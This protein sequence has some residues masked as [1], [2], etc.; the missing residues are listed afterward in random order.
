MLYKD[1]MNMKTLLTS[2]P[3]KLYSPLLWYTNIYLS[4][5]LALIL[6]NYFTLSASVFPLFL[7]FWTF[8]FAFSSFHTFSPNIYSAI[9]DPPPAPSINK[10]FP[11]GMLADPY[12]TFQFYMDPDPD[13][14]LD[15]VQKLI[16]N[17][18]VI[19]VDAGAA[20]WGRFVSSFKTFIQRIQQQKS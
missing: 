1:Y 5:P 2:P 15:E 20:V 16:S 18:Y 17:G 4:C 13:P 7:F 3:R 6:D 8:L 9:S 11:E 10:G 14:I 12:P 19:G